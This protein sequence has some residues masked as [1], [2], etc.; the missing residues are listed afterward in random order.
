MATNVEAII[1]LAQRLSATELRSVSYE[2]DDMA[3]EK[4]K[5]ECEQ[6]GHQI[7]NDQ[8]GRAEHRFCHHCQQRE[9]AINQAR[10]AKANEAPDGKSGLP[11]ESLGSG[12]NTDLSQRG[13]TQAD[14]SPNKTK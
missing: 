2:L 14:P 12:S 1:E 5:D 3:D 7:D 10:E 13:D 6:N 4:A 8:C 11:S 9:T